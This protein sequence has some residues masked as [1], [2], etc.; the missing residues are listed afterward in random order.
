MTNPQIQERLEGTD[1]AEVLRAINLICGAAVDNGKF[2]HLKGGCGKEVNAHDA[3][4]CVDCTASFHRD[5]MRQHLK[6]E[7]EK[8]KAIA[9]LEAKVRKAAELLGTARGTLEAH[10]S[11]ELAFEIEQFLSPPEQ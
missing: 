3:Y 4:R 9:A 6:D 5:C 11:D 8:D 10:D 7:T 2:V 1:H